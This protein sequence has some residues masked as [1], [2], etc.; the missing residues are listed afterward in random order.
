ME[1]IAKKFT[2][3]CVYEKASLLIAAFNDLQCALAFITAAFVEGGN[4]N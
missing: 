4:T 3:D 1:T 2:P